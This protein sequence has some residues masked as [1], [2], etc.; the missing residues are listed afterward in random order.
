L[1]L[2]KEAAKKAIY[3]SVLHSWAAFD[4][5][6]FYEACNF[7]D[8]LRDPSALPRSWFKDATSKIQHRHPLL[9]MRAAD[10]FAHED[11]PRLLATVDE[12]IPIFPTY[13]HLYWLKGAALYHLDR[14]PEAVE[15]LRI[16][17]RYSKDEMEYPQAMEWLKQIQLVAK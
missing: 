1:A 5:S 10:A 15:P 7:A 17:T 11:W 12:A 8:A 2:T 9:F 13:Y 3:R 4:P 6:D 14:K 16:Y